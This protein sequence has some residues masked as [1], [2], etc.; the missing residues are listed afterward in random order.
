MR[1]RAGLTL[2]PAQTTGAQC[3]KFEINADGNTEVVG[4]DGQVRPRPHE[5]TRSEPSWSGRDA[6]PRGRVALALILFR[7]RPT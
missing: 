2:S 6:H 7:I 1:V 4:Y 3:F 5:H